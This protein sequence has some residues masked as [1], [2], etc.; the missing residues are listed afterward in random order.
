MISLLTYH[1]EFKQAVMAS[2]RQK[3]ASL[4]DDKWMYEEEEVG[5]DSS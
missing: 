4:D 1:A 3:V 2:L 5:N